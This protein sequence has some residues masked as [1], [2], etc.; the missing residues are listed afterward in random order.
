M[1]TENLETEINSSLE[2]TIS[3]LFQ[4]ELKTLKDKY[5]NLMRNSY[6]ITKAK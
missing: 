4:K 1:K 6:S 5:E 2:S 3:F